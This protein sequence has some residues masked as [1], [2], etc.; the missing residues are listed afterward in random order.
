EPLVQL[1]RIGV[2][3]SLA[4][5][6]YP[7]NGQTA[8]LSPTFYGSVGFPEVSGN[9]FP[10]HQPRR[11]IL[12]RIGIGEIG[13]RKRH[14]VYLYLARG[15][16]CHSSDTTCHLVLRHFALMI[17]PVGCITVTLSCPPAYTRISSGSHA[18]ERG[19]RSSA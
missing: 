16:N 15:P 18:S 14:G 5:S 19:S 11:S 8:T 17:A 4:H 6:R 10:P 2:D 1:R 13:V 7:M 9:L 3:R 12:F